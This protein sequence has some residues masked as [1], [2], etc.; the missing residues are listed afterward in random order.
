[1]CL[2][3]RL[4]IKCRRFICWLYAAG[5]L[6]ASVIPS[7]TL[8]APDLF[9]N[10]DKVLHALMY[11][12]WV[13]LLCWTSQDRLRRRWSTWIAIIVIVATA[14]G[15]LMEGMQWLLTWS[16]RACSVGDMLANLAGAVAG[17]GLWI[18]LHGR[19]RDKTTPEAV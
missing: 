18:W 14:Y 8:A 11:G 2:S 12:G 19:P 4:D 5:I 1:M 9:P 16:R 7:P 3:L 17:A 6:V 13:L 10:Q 15:I